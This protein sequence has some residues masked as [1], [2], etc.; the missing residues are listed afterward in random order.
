MLGLVNET[1]ALSQVVA[2]WQLFFLTSVGYNGAVRR[3]AKAALYAIK[4]HD[5]Q[6]L[7]QLHAEVTTMLVEWYETVH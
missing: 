4:E 2:E 1:S 3:Q 7:S 5:E 6:R